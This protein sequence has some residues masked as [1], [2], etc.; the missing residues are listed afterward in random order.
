MWGG[1]SG[2]A[3]CVKREACNSFHASATTIYQFNLIYIF[4]KGKTGIQWERMN[5]S[6]LG[7]SV[8]KH[9]LQFLENH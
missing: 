5:E 1:G 6:T 9:F 7:Q 2:S 3:V 8:S 4:Y